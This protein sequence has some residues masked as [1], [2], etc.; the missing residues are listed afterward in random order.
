MAHYGE[1]NGLSFIP[2]EMD[3]DGLG[4]SLIPPGKNLLFLSYAFLIQTVFIL[5]LSTTG[6]IYT[7]TSSQHD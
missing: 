1:G 2:H 5:C 7:R 6:F 3:G 4:D